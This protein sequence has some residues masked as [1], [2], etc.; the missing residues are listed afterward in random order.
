VLLG[1]DPEQARY[2]L[3][4]AVYVDE[5]GLSLHRA[6]NERATRYALAQSGAARQ[7][8]VDPGTPLSGLPY[9][10]HGDAVL[11][12]QGAGGE[13]TDVPERFLDPGYLGW[14]FDPTPFDQPLPPQ[15]SPPGPAPGPGSRIGRPLGWLAARASRPRGAR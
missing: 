14:S 12:G 3:D 11:V 15:A 13:L 6:R 4:A 8:G 9:F 10:L 1:G 7:R 2:D 5:N